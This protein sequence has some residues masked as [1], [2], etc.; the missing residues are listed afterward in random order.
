MWKIVK[1]F[2]AMV[3]VTVCFFTVM[4]VYLNPA[5]VSISFGFLKVSKYPVS[6]WIIGAFVFGG[7]VGLILGCNWVQ[8]TKSRMEIKNLNKKLVRANQMVKD[9]RSTSFV[10]HKP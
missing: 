9:L 7:S 4:F 8:N 6:V 1:F 3:L 10:N 2:S 5:L